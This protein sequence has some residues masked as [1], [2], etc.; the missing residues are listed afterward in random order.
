[1]DP[2]DN[3]IRDLQAGW[4]PILEVWEGYATDPDIRSRGSSGGLAT[5]LTLYCIEKEGVHGAVLTAGDE[6]APHRNTT[7]FS[8]NRSDILSTTGSRYSPASPCDSLK[9]IEDADGPCL[10]LGKPCDVEGLRKA[11]AMRPKLDKNLY[12][13]IGI[14][15]AGTPSTKGTLDLLRKHGLAVKDVDE[16]RY[17]GRGW[18][19]QFAV[20]KNG[21]SEWNDLASYEDSWGFLQKYRPYRCYLCPDS[22]SEFADLSCGDPW[23]R[24][25]E[26]DN[27]RSLVVV[28]T[29]K[30]RSIVAGAIEAG[31]VHLKIAA[32]DVLELSQ[33]NLAH[34]RGAIW[35]RL[36]TLKMFGVPAPRIQGFLLFRNWLR[37]PV[38][39]KVRSI[40]GTARR[41][42][43]RHYRKPL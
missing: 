19:G 16:I 10:F 43:K 29:E 8:K 14:F 33:K 11:Q 2:Q 27:G 3:L 7:L 5:A 24:P 35:G 1:L 39:D 42:V 20:R 6:K 41:I 34:K 30:G 25:T 12:A 26:G 40:A 23:Y 4:G 36:L 22:T 31:Y 28:R 37:L 32:P 38:A 17:R 13:A 21:H 15:C 18:P 9:S